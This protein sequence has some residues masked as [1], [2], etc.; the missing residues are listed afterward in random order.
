MEYFSLYNLALRLFERNDLERA[1][2]YMQR[3]LDDAL[4]CKSG[5]R[6]PL[7]SSA[8]TAINRAVVN[9]LA[10]RNRLRLWTTA[11]T[12]LLLVNFAAAFGYFRG[13]CSTAGGNWPSP[14][15]NSVKRTGS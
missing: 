6:I 3:T 15:P 1:S 9:D 14:M 12:S 7:T 5:A 11:V 4:A 13:G 2:R 8:A 10:V